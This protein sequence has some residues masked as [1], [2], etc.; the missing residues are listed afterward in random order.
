MN[1]NKYIKFLS[2]LLLLFYFSA[3]GK[4]Q[5]KPDQLL[6]PDPKILI[7]T[8]E[9]GLKYY[10][11]ENRK[12]EKR[13]ELRLVVKAGSVLEDDD[14]QGIAHF[15]E[16]MAFNGTKSYPKHALIDFLEKA[17]V[18]FGPDLNAYT[19]FDETVYMLQV[20]TDT[21]EVIE[22]ALHIL[23]EWASTV[24]FE[25][26]EIDKERG[27]V[28]EEWRLRRNANYRVAMK[29]IPYEL[30]KSRYAERIVIGKKEILESC[31]YDALKNFYRDWY[32]PDLMAVLAVGDFDKNE[33]EKL[34]KKHFSRLK[35]PENEKVR[36]QYSVPDHKETLVSIARDQELT[37]TSVE[38]MFKRDGREDKTV[39]DY[40]R[41]IIRNLYNEMLN[42]RLDELVQNPDPPFVEAYAYS[43]RLIDS[44]YA[45]YVGIVAKETGILS[46]L[47]SALREVFRV[48]QHGFTESELERS[49]LQ[50]LSRMEQFYRERDKTES[51]TLINE[52]T[53]NFLTE[54][55]IPGIEVE[56]EL[57]KQFLPTITV[58]DVNELT[59]EMITEHNRVVTISAPDKEDI[60]VPSESDVLTAIEKVSN[61]RLAPYVDKIGEGSLIP[62]MP[63]CGKIVE[64]KKIPSLN[65][66]EWKLSNG[67]KVV[68]KPT[69][70]KDDEVLFSAYS[71]GGTSL[72]NDS[73]YVSAS[74]ASTII[75]QSGIADFDLISLRKKL[76]GKIVSITPVIDDLSEGF[77]GS[78]SPRDL[79][80]LF[81]LVFL[82]GTSPR[83]DTLAFS[84]VISRYKEM[85]QNR[86]ANPEASFN[87]TIKVTLA[88]Y[89]RRARPLTLQLIDEI[90][91]CKSIS[92]Y[93]DRYAD[94]SDFIFFIVG[95]FNIDS[96]KPFV[97]CYLASLPSVQRN[98]S[99]KDVGIK[100]PKGLIT[101]EVIK[102]IEPK[103]MVNITFTGE[104]E[105]SQKNRHIFNSM[106]DVLN[107]RLREVLREDKGGTYGVRVSGNTTLFPR[108][109]Y[110]I[111]ISWGCNP[112]RVDELVK[113]ALLQIDSLR[114]KPVDAIY[115]EKVKEIQ[116]RSF[117]VNLK[118]NNFWL[119][120]L[121]FYYS[122]G[123]NPE[124][125]LNYPSLV[126]SLTAVDIQ[127]AAK[128]YFDM[129]N[130]IK[131]IL[132]PEKR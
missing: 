33:I 88:N 132:Y 83:K 18:K 81:Q 7:G 47:E 64:E 57:Y 110:S 85:V 69:D 124:M 80:T 27:V 42:A 60:K 63:E 13:A 78:A 1:N 105:W 35:N 40:R 128:K 84:S 49:K 59:D 123:E 129:N 94:F 102:G 75:E 38:I 118:R 56:L 51:R 50:L 12:P 74:F 3:K 119:M 97:E 130:F 16:H 61:E 116:K 122:N 108:S 9:N 96:I 125:I 98:E 4:E 30:Y 99:W 127:K 120:N 77:S 41:T 67:A 86:K 5:F 62:K 52:Y 68:L 109:E 25:D 131:V 66:T 21:P 82:Y 55:P 26:E 95:N 17:G 71:P 121:Q 114:I 100:P 89:H 20:P 91:L 101:K 53:R 72:S 24:T 93:K 19:S 126:D 14:Q 107:I 44:K 43:G 103:S 54:E 46:G 39:G 87:D 36:M 28:I 90:N 79:E 113:E 92:F 106:I 73:D 58:K 34:I 76:A 37:E 70:F 32:R 22:K 31:P 48:R 45:F 112:Q 8:L 2:L 6:T 117:E 115:V 11:R 29:H 10:I 65:V 111:T 23:E 15:V 104:F